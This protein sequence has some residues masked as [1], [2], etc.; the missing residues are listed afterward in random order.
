MTDREEPP[1]SGTVAWAGTLAAAAV[2][3]TLATACMMPFVGMA[4]AAAATMPRAR[5]A[6]TV[7]MAWAANQLLGFALLGYPPTALAISWGA[8]LGL[9]ALLATLVGAAVLGR[10]RHTPTG[11]VLAFVIAF[12]SYEL[13]LFGFAQLAG[14]AGTFTRD[15]VLRI[16]G[17]DAGWYAVLLAIRAVLGRTA[18]RTFG[19]ALAL[20][21]A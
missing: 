19:P 5:A 16:L 21:R 20:R 2:L 17:N 9:A 8:A 11:L 1:Q 6:A 3:G 12:A 15:I 18:P 14:G 13:G 4:V 10:T 7:A